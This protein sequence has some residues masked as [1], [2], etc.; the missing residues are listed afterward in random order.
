M[1]I[2]YAEY[3]VVPN[4]KYIYTTKNTYKDNTFFC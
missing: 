4:L 2:G 1:G 3:G